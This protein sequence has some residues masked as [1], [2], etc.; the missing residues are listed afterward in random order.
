MCSNEATVPT[1]GSRYS[2]QAPSPAAATIEAA[3]NAKLTPAAPGWANVEGSRVL[4]D[5]FSAIAQ[6]GDVT[7]LAGKAD[8]QMSG[9]LNG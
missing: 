1:T 4:E 7:E 9:Q 8:E 3:S 6:G 2:N 5:L